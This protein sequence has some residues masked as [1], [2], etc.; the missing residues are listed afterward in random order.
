MQNSYL[1][2]VIVSRRLM[3]NMINLMSHQERNIRAIYV[4]ERNN[5]N[6]ENPYSYFIYN[7]TANTPGSN[8]AGSN[9]A[10]S[11]TPGS[12]TAG[13]NTPVSNTAGLNTPGSNTP[14]SNT[15][16]SNNTTYITQP[17]NRPQPQRSN[18][19]RR[20]TST[21]GPR[22]TT[23]SAENTHLRFNNLFTPTR[24]ISRNRRANIPTALEINTATNSNT[25][26]NIESPQNTTCPITRDAFEPSDNVTQIIQCGHTFNRNNLY[27]WFEHNSVCPM[28]RYDVR[29][30]SRVDAV[31]NDTT[32]SANVVDDANRD[33]DNRELTNIAEQIA[34]DILSNISDTPSNISLEYSLYAPIENNSTQPNY[35]THRT[36]YDPSLNIG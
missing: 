3:N 1:D 16:G 4:T 17:I 28:C 23:P 33:G 31:N 10:G 30:Y 9:T 26:E 8:T 15:P 18:G 32:I 19:N 7:E 12:N 29:S 6:R 34:N 14:G 2:D 27:E 35:M 24:G 20:Q 25:F 36:S 11:N 22:V 13:L 5:V 21:N